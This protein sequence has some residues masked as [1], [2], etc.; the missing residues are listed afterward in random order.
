MELPVLTRISYFM[1]SGNVWLAKAFSN[2]PIGVYT[3]EHETHELPLSEK[4]G[5]RQR[6][7]FR[8]LAD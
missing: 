8:A 6:S 2:S 4:G 1:T 5:L 3:S 7:T